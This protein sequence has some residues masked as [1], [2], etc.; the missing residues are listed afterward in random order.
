[1]GTIVDKFNKT[2]DT[3]ARIAAAIEEKTG[4]PAGDVFASY[5]DQI[6][7]IPSGGWTGHADEAGLKAIGWT[8]DDIAYYQKYGVNWNEEDDAYHKVPQENIDLYGVLTV[9]N[10]STYKD[11]I[12][13]L[14]KIDTSGETSMV[15]KFSGCY[16]L[17]AIPM[18]DTS[19]VTNMHYMFWNCRSLVSIPLLDTSSV[20]DMSDMFENCYSLVS[21]PLLDTSSVTDMSYMF[22]GCGSLVSI[23]LLDTSSV[24]DMSYMFYSCFSLVSIPLLDTSSVIDMPN[25]FVSCFSLVYIPS[26]DVSNL[27][28]TGSMFR[29]C[30]SERFCNLKYL[31]SSIDISATS[32]LEKSSLLYMIEN[33]VSPFAVTRAPDP[34][35]V[36]TL[37]SYCYN[38]Y[39]DDPDITVALSKKIFIQI[40][41][42]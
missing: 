8:D 13:Y 38:K 4:K 16:S 18:I 19:S 27:M 15:S 7:Q 6:L 42:A 14:P 26:L 30:Q 36:I 12:V 21:I 31:K 32:L 9:D 28:T 24:T 33:A 40:A 39:K 17:V 1:M 35:I 5:P 11:R 20:T 25:M 10:I 3:K 34:L 41:S 29:N 22:Y 37:S 2:L 23:P